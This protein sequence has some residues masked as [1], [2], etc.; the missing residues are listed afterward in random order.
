MRAYTEGGS[1]RDVYVKYTLINRTP[2]IW[3]STSGCIVSKSYY[4]LVLKKDMFDD[5]YISKI[6]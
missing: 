6:V 5:V 1:M 2:T 4:M 3:G